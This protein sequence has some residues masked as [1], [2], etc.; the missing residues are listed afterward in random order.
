MP[1]NNTIPPAI[2]IEPTCFEPNFLASIHEVPVRTKPGAALI[3]MNCKTFAA[4]SLKKSASV[5]SIM[6]LKSVIISAAN[7]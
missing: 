5:D 4:G 7:I 2:I 3:D 1:T 6:K